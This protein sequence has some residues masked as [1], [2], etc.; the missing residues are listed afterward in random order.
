MKKCEFAATTA[1]SLKIHIKIKHE[2]VR[3]PSDKCHYTT[4]GAGYLRRHT[5]CKHARVRY[6]CD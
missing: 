3:Y 5:K 1:S 6:P 2:G 4:T